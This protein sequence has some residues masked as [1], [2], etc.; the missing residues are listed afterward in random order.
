ME[1]KLKNYDVDRQ[2]LHKQNPFR[3][4]IVILKHHLKLAG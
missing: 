3:K 1:D 2:E 4:E